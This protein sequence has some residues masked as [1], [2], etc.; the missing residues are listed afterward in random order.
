MP[1]GGLDGAAAHH[2]EPSPKAALY[3]RALC[4]AIRLDDS[5]AYDSAATE[6]DGWKR[7]RRAR[8]IISRRRLGNVLAKRRS[9]PSCA[10]GPRCLDSAATET[11]PRSGSRRSTEGRGVYAACYIAARPASTRAFGVRNRV[12]S[13]AHHAPRRRSSGAGLR[14]AELARRVSTH[15]NAPRPDKALQAGVPGPA[16]DLGRLIRWGLFDTRVRAQSR[17][18]RF[19]ADPKCHMRC[20]RQGERVADVECLVVWERRGGCSRRADR[21]QACS[22]ARFRHDAELRRRQPQNS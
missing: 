5:G 19:A 4:P 2:A 14:A 6:E 7:P 18:K 3:R 20:V 22:R 17:A 21:R 16:A 1:V 12:L 15:G 13:L 8:R 11:E 10:A 9:R